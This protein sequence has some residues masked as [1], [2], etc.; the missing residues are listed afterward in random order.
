MSGFEI[1]CEILGVFPILYDGG[2]DLKGVYRNFR[3]WWRFDREF[4]DFI[5][6]IDREHIAFSQNLDILLSSLDLSDDDR[7]RLQNG[8]DSRLWHQPHIQ[9]ELRRRLQDRYYPWF[10][11]QL[12]DID[13]ALKELHGLLPI[14]KV[15]AR[16]STSWNGSC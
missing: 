10:V 11:R 4:E 13:E 16:G 5:S 1:A 12:T 6:G 9:Q 7:E 15:G 3:T 14:G 8:V 2:K